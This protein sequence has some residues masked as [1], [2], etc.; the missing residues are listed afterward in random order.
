[1]VAPR[2]CVLVLRKFM[3][4]G[5]GIVEYNSV[6]EA[7][8]AY[9]QLNDTMLD[10]RLIFVREDRED[11]HFGSGRGRLSFLCLYLKFPLVPAASHL[12]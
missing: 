7:R 9:V 8:A 3:Q 5:C 1:M 4:P 12:S 11:R 6:D 10:G 2:V